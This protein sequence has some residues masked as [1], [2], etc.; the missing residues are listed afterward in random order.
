[1]PPCTG[2]SRY[3]PFRLER[4][5]VDPR[6]EVYKHWYAVAVIAPAWYRAALCAEIGERDGEVVYSEVMDS[7][8]L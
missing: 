2:G 1:M 5:D 6:A 7:P 4:Q 3:Y 8:K